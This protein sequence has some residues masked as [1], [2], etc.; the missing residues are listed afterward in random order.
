M[1]SQVSIGLRILRKNGKIFKTTNKPRMNG[2][3]ITG[4]LSISLKEERT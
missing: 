1:L 3:N 2:I 4:A